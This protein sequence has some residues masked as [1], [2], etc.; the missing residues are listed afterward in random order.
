MQERVVQETPGL[1]D[2][3]QSP[4][5]ITAVPILCC[6]VFYTNAV[7]PFQTRSANNHAENVKI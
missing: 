7:K 2:D 5:Y 4:S 6:P 1:P 3:N